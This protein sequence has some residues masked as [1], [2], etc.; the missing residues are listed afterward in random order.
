MPS[1]VREATLHHAPLI[2][3]FGSM[4]FK[5]LSHESL[6][7]RCYRKMTSGFKGERVWF[8]I[9]LTPLVT[10]AGTLPTNW[11][12]LK[13]LRTLNLDR[14]AL[15]GKPTLVLTMTP[16]CCNAWQRQ[17]L[18]VEEIWPA[19]ISGIAFHKDAEH[20]WSQSSAEFD[21]LRTLQGPYLHPGD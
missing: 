7:L 12:S 1:Q 5:N 16:E 14:N 21:L 9:L 20:A 6:S 17:D 8:F 3:S 15:T 10:C 13:S 18:Y 4:S 11:T 2:R 19:L